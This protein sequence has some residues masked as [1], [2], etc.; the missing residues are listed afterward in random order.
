[1]YAEYPRAEPDLKAYMAYVLRRALP[2]GDAIDYQSAGDQGEGRSYRHA[3]A[4]NELWDARARMSAYGRALLLLL[5]DEAKDARGNELAQALIGEAQSAGELTWWAVDHDPLLF[6]FADTS[7]EATATALQALARRDPSSP[8]LDRGVRWLMAESPRRLLVHDQA[9]GD[10]ALR[11]ARGAA[12]AQRDRRAVQRGRLRQRRARRHAQ[13]HRGVADGARSD[14]RLRGRAARAP[15]ACGWSRRAAARSTGRRSA[16]YY[17]TQGAA[18]RSGSR[19]L[20]ITRKYARLAPVRVKDRIVYREEPFD[21][22][23]NPGDV[24]TI[25][26]T[27]AGSKDWRYLMVEDPLPAGVEAVQDTTAYP[28]EREDRWRWWWG[29]Q[30]EYRDNRTVFFQERFDEGRSRVRLSGEGDLLGSVPRGAGAGGAD[31]RAGR[32]RL[33]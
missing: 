6:D 18:A 21:G 28:M 2:E 33:V 23:M 32:D 25:R 31:V 12:G 4:R 20:A 7:V 5:L 8:L 10:R 17:D 29:S 11:P 30:V 15:T 13:L 1:M 26:L 27:I 19:Q 16:T 22:R 9:D 3:D 24:L 14:R